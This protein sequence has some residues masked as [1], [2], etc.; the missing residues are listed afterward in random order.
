MGKIFNPGEFDKRITF[1]KRGSGQD[2]YGDP[3]E[4]WTEHKKAW[5]KKFDLTGTDFYASQTQDTKIEVKFNCRF[6][7]GVTKDMRIQCGSG[8]YEI[9]GVPI[10]IDRRELL[11]YCRAV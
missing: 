9:I 6:I 4:T 1:L 8:M 7:T 2:D 11:I 3:I 10:D 5:A